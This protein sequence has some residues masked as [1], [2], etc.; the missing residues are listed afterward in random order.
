[1]EPAIA[2]VFYRQASLHWQCGSGTGNMQYYLSFGL[3]VWRFHS[4]LLATTTGTFAEFGES[5]STV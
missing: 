2:Q 4:F 5:E 3:A 1:V